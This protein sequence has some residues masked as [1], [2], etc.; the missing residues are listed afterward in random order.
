MSSPRQPGMNMRSWGQ[1]RDVFAKIRSNDE[2]K[3]YLHE[4][5]RRVGARDASETYRLGIIALDH[6]QQEDPDLIGALLEAM[7][8]KCGHRP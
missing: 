6:L 5:R 1:G 2:D 4:V 7:K 8:A 3:A